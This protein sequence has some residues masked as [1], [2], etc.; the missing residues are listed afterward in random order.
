MRYT[1][2][3]HGLK[4]PRGKWVEVPLVHLTFSPWGGPPIEDDYGGKPVVEHN[5][6]PAYAELAILRLLENQGWEG[7]WVDTFR[8][9]YLVDLPENDG[10]SSL[11]D[12]Q[13]SLLQKIRKRNGGLSGCWDI[14]ASRDGK[15]LFAESKWRN[16]DAIRA[17]QREWLQAALAA[18]LTAEDFLI[19]EWDLSS[20]SGG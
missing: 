5:G 4:L 20:S 7:V 13:E 14:F 2:R 3:R 16:N 12:D 6:E 17:S 9:R 11:S 10:E 15:V 1:Q 19:V 8:N 18:P